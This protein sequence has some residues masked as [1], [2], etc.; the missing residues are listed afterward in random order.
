[1]IL[2]EDYL[3][4]TAQ[5]QSRLK[6]ILLHP[7]LYINYDPNSD[8]DEPAEV[9][10]IG[11]GVDLLLTQGEDVFMEQFYFSTVE[12]P[13][14]QMGD[15]V[16]HLFANRNDTMAENIAYELAGFK[17]DTLA[18]VRERFEKEGKAY[19]DDLIAGEGKKVVSPIQYATIQNV[20]NTLKMSPFT[21]KYV[22]GNSQFKVFTQQS[23]QFEYEGVACKGLLDLV[24]VDTVNN[25][26]YPIDLK[27]TTTSLNYWIEML[28]KHR[29]D[30]QA[31]FYTEALKQTDL[32]IYGENL[33]IHNF[34]F[35]VE[36]QKYPG[37]PLIYE[38]SDKLMDLGKTGGTYLG[39]EYEGF[40]QAI[41]RLKWHSEN[42]LWAYT[43]EDYQN[44]GLRIV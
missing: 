35:I 29:Y 13:T 6:K 2:D 25:I 28:L 30:F 15:F 22:V 23:L 16:W 26:L 14:G 42:D 3:S 31:A 34:R 9:T 7:N 41:E 39:K 8:M 21:S 38:M 5:S 4:N 44:D 33:T 19:Y 11:D 24:V 12:R 20:A 36:S 32:S 10:V 27:T 43:M 17:R 18:K 37:S 1:M 40:H